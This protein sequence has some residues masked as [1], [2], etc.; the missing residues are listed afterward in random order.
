MTKDNISTAVNRILI[1]VIKVSYNREVKNIS[2]LKSLQTKNIYR[3]H[4]QFCIDQKLHLHK[5]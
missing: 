4:I 5:I 3:K 2:L 1:H